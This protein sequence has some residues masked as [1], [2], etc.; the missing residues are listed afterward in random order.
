MSK[1]P[2]PSHRGRVDVNRLAIECVQL[3]HKLHAAGLYA[4]GHKMHEVVRKIGWE[5]AERRARK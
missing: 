1:R 2:T 3:H 5:L 4:S